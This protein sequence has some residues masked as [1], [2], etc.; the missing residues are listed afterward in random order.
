MH[1]HLHG[2]RRTGL[3]LGYCVELMSLEAHFVCEL[4]LPRS[5]QRRQEHELTHFHRFLLHLQSHHVL[6]SQCVLA[7][8]VVVAA[9]IVTY[10]SHPWHALYELS[11]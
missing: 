4:S 5:T 3:I 8:T 11:S 9:W 1:C 10:P 7:C 6:E 2:A